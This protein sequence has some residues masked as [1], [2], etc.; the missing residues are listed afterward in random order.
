MEL[1]DQ[2]E[3]VMDDVAENEVVTSSDAEMALRTPPVDYEVDA[4]L[5]T[6]C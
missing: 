1:G 5:M 6:C 2:E 3:Q 4:R